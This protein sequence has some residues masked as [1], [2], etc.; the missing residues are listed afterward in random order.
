MALKPWRWLLVLSY[1]GT[2][3]LYM[4][5]YSK[6]YERAELSLTLIFATLFFAV[7]AI[8]PLIAAEPQEEIAVFASIA[9]VISFV[10]AGVYFLQAYTMV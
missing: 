6:F 9:P 5:W 3:L 7:F 8:A 10:N 2:L 4:G 1:A